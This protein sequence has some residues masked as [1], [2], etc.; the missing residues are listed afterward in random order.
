MVTSGPLSE[1]WAGRPSRGLDG[2]VQAASK[3]YE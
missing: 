2:R 3:A 1:V